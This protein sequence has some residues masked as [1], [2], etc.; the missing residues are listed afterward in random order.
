M[1]ILEQYAVMAK[2]FVLGFDLPISGLDNS[3][4][5]KTLDFFLN[6]MNNERVHFIFQFEIRKCYFVPNT[7][8]QFPIFL[9]FVK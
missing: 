8:K 7:K 3:R 1:M 6:S 2:G 9:Q 5:N 4:T